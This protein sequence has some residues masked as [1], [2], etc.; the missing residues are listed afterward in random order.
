MKRILLFLFSILL[1][2]GC[3]NKNKNI[4]KNLDKKISS[5]KSYHLEGTLAINRGDDIYK[6]DVNCS[7]K[8]GNY[9]RVSLT[10][11]INNHEQI[12]LR[13]D[14]GV[15]VLN[16]TLNKSF[17]FE[18][19]WPHNNSGLYLL[20]TVLTDLKND[21]ERKIEKTKNGYIIKSKVNYINNSNL[22]YQKV[23]LDNEYNITKVEVYNKNDKLE[24]KMEFKNIDYKTK[25]DKDYF[26]LKENNENNLLEKTT[27]KIS[28]VIYPMYLPDNTYLTN[29]ET[30][31][32]SNGERV[33]LNFDGDSSFMLV[34]ETV[35]IPDDLE[36]YMVY[37]EPDLILDTVGSVTDYS[38]SWISNGVEYYLVSNDMSSEQL[39][40]V[41][42]SI[43][44]MPVGK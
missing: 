42:S 36:T 31:K 15:Y 34:E 28:D 26:S 5:T 30:I 14:S 7:S 9:Y 38:V 43:N 6:Y 22:V 32:T 11:Q 3:G 29:Q 35:S 2:V 16:P 27:A 40:S 17:K 13:N 1:L 21:D 33:V 39:V 41:A 23:Y 37:G 12:I 4:L 24:M 20:E 44:V 19:D 25:F 18:S 8:D 10:N